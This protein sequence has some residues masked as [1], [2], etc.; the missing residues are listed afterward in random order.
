MAL[1]IPVSRALNKSNLGSEGQT[2][3]DEDREHGEDVAMELEEAGKVRMRSKSI[4][5]HSPSLGV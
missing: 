4:K 5:Y 2:K 3:K 1:L